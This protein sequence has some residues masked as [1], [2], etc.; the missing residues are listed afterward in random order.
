M[1]SATCARASRRAVLSTSVCRAG[2]SGLQRCILNQITRQG[3]VRAQH[4][5]HQPA[6]FFWSRCA[7]H[8]HAAG[9]TSMPPPC[10]APAT[11]LPH[12]CHTPATNCLLPCFCTS[13][14]P[15]L[16]C[17]I[18]CL[19]DYSS[20]PTNS[21]LPCHCACVGLATVKAGTRLPTEDDLILY[22]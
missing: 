20:R 10:H 7:A 2:R 8:H 15:A 1:I 18:D 9:A 6:A 16:P 4:G 22:T 5:E 14:C 3:G 11:P 13:P 17:M 21:K 12:P 19:Q